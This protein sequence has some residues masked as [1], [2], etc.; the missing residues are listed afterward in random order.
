MKK[1]IYIVGL[2]ALTVVIIVT[3]IKFV[4]RYNETKD[5]VC[6]F[7]AKDDEWMATYTSIKING[8]NHDS[9]YFEYIGYDSKKDYIDKISY[10]LQDKNFNIPQFETIDFKNSYDVHTLITDAN[11]SLM[12]VRKQYELKLTINSLKGAHYLVLK[13]V[14]V[15][16]YSA[17]Q[18]EDE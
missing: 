3:C 17:E 4:I 15:H 13:R 5:G 6:A 2:I 11:E 1:R 8:T 14:G 18:D 10:A 16:Y 12:D 7:Y 9:L